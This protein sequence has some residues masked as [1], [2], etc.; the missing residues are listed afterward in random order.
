MPRN[1]HYCRTLA[2]NLLA[3]IEDEDT[4]DR[5]DAVIEGSWNDQVSLEE[6]CEDLREEVKIQ[7]L[8]Q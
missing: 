5:F 7:D 4:N 8:F 6:I 2:S 1:L 3:Q